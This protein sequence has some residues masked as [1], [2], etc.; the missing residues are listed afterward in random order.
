[1]IKWRDVLPPLQFFFFWQPARS[2]FHT[3]K[4]FLSMVTSNLTTIVPFYLIFIH[5]FDLGVPLTK[6]RHIFY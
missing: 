1:M 4:F 6:I 3:Y 5:S 2:G